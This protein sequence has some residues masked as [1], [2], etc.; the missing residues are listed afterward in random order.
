MAFKAVLSSSLACWMLTI[1]LIFKRRGRCLAGGEGIQDFTLMGTQKL[2]EF[3][4]R[5]LISDPFRVMTRAEI[6]EPEKTTQML[7]SQNIL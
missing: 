1:S 5:E 6:Q 4:E 7:Q 3:W 2:Q